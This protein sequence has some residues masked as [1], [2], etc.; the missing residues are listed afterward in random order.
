MLGFASIILIT[1]G[2]QSMGKVGA[3]VFRLVRIIVNSSRINRWFPVHLIAKRNLLL[4][5]LCMPAWVKLINSF[6]HHLQL[7]ISEYSCCKTPLHIIA[8]LHFSFHT[9]AIHGR[10]LNKLLSQA[11][12]SSPVVLLLLSQEGIFSRHVTRIKNRITD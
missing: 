4:L 9:A 10:K 2:T 11:L 7:H 6:F 3:N 5:Q 1:L 8:R 12:E